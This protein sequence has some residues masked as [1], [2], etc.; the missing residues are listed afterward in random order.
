MMDKERV[1]VRKEMNNINIE[2]C[3][4]NYWQAGKT[5]TIPPPPI[6]Q[7]AKR[8]NKTITVI[9]NIDHKITDKSQGLILEKERLL[10]WKLAEIRHNR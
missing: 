1:W 8:Y 5:W 7:I 3:S 6:K 10:A 9:Q 2:Q 4:I